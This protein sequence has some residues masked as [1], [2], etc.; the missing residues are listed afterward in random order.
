ME[1]P[2]CCATGFFFYFRFVL[3]KTFI[4]SI[5]LVPVVC[6]SQQTL[7]DTTFIQ[8]ALQNETNSFRSGRTIGVSAGIGAVWAGSMIGLHSIWYKDMDRSKWHTF[9]DSRE[10]MQMDK[11][12]HVYTANK[13]SGLTYDLYRW[14]GWKNN[15]A[16]WMGFG[17]G[18]GYQFT[19]E[20]LDATGKDWGFSWSDMGANT[21]GSGLFLA[22]QLLWKEQRFIP[23]FS[24][25]K[26]LYAVHRPD[27]LG[28][29][30]PERLL[31][32]YNGQTYWLSF[33]PAT[34]IENTRFPK[35]LC[36]SVGY[37]VDAKLHGEKDIYVGGVGTD[38]Q[39]FHA[40][41]QLLLSLDIDFSKLPIKKPWLKAIVKQFNYLKLPF[42]TIILTGNQW[43]G[44][45][46]YF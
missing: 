39:V 4:F 43:Q 16:A 9:D 33:T 38:V 22:Q 41:R 14:A 25:S 42:P 6:F 12:G 15:S 11:A 24:F 34:F 17:V 18:M 19:L 7:S 3:I 46:I 37:G 28:S 29:N 8:P 10:W 31:K 44:K 30:F 32:D 35:W 21:I 5:L 13:I 26:S 20:C 45:W 1:I 27:A 23:K 2:W 40:K 36:L